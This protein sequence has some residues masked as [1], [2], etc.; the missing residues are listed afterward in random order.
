MDL[1][2][3]PYQYEGRDWLT[4]HHHG[5]LADQPGLGKSAQAII[6]A[7]RLGAERILVV[8]PAIARGNW[9]NEFALWSTPEKRY[10]LRVVEAR[11]QPAPTKHGYIVS[12]DLAHASP[13][14]TYFSSQTWD[15]VILDESHYAKEPTSRRSKA[16]YGKKDL[17]GLVHFTHHLWAL[18]GTPTPNHAGELWTFLYAVGAT[19]LSYDAFL[20]RYCEQIVTPF[21]TP[22]GAPIL[23]VV[24]N[25]ADRTG[26]L[27]TLLRPWV[28]RRLK[29][30]VLPH[31]PP[32]LFSEVIVPPSPVRLDEWFQ[33]TIYKNGEQ[34]VEYDIDRQE[35]A[36]QFVLDT[37]KTDDARLQALDAMQIYQGTGPLRRYTALQKTPAIAE[38]IADELR[39][40]AYPKIV[41]F[42]WHRDPMTDLY[43]RLH[44]E[45][46][47]EQ[48]YGGTP[49][50]KRERIVRDFQR[51]PRV[52]GI[53]LQIRA[54]GI[55]INLTAAD[56]VGMVE[57]SWVDDEN[58]Q[59]VMRVHRQGQ[60]SHKVRVRFFTL[61]N[62]TDQFVQRVCRRKLRDNKELWDGQSGDDDRR[63]ELKAMF[64]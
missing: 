34:K 8:C 20:D 23:R 18:S 7:E 57:S 43:N 3:F 54:A 46:R 27:R 62:S 9:L 2:P 58:L 37:C 29:V 48:I 31:L 22:Y 16:A 61:A 15:V 21:R 11:T 45:F 63:E 13:I 1:V 24:G 53:I 38:L 36:V 39:N 49:I 47:M 33:E 4:Q 30:N 19:P 50:D 6:A 64:E 56:E 40:N 60:T 12:W 44:K 59:A 26:E 5:L 51:D 42:A 35:A 10:D 41:L 28:L 25:R 55:S 32:I 17:G 14:S 52:R